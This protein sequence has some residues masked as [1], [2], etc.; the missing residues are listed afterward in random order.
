MKITIAS[1]RRKLLYEIYQDDE[2]V[3]N[4]EYNAKI[5]RSMQQAHVDYDRALL[6]PG[7]Q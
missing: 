7:T 4:W 1:I 5:Q 2:L 3:R 6:Y